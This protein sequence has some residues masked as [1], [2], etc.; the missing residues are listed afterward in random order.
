MLFKKYYI[1]IP[2]KVVPQFEKKTVWSEKA[3]SWLN[4]NIRDA[5]TGSK[6]MFK[7]WEAYPH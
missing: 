7:K 2:G 3:I 6:L 4:R 5:I 1:K